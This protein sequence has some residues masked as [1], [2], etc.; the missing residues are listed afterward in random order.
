MKLITSRKTWALVCCL[1]LALFVVSSLL[2]APYLPRLIRE[3][4]PKSTWPAPG[5]FVQITGDKSGAHPLKIKTPRGVPNGRLRKLIHDSEAKALLVYTGDALQLEHYA[6]GV[7]AGTRFNSYSLVKSLIG[8]LV[9]KAHAENR[10]SDLN[11]AIGK[12]LPNMGNENLRSVPLQSFLDMKSGIIFETD[13]TKS[14]SGIDEKDMEASLVNPFGPMA[15]L[16]MNG[17][18]AVQNSLSSQKTAQTKFSY[19]NI[20]TAL[21]GA[22]LENIYQTPLHKILNEKIWHPAGAGQAHWRRHAENIGVTAYCCIYAKPR[23]WVKVAVFV[24]RNGKPGKPF[25]PQNLWDKVFGMDLSSK[26]LVKGVYRN[27]MRYDI[28]DRKG[29]PLQ[30]RFTYFMGSGGQTIYLMPDNGL[31]VVRFGDKLQLLHSTLYAAWRSIGR[32]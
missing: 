31:V 30:G 23:D 15:R 18:N 17:L 19:Q 21:L 10:I 13:E 2:A 1:A 12:Y 4:F 6:T 29:E 24:M 11:D 22:M 8:L 9:L 3:G 25:L 5:Y 16:H 14:V 26:D 7:L 28:L 20:N 27:H 32:H